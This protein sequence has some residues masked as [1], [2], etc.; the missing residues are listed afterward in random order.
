MEFKRL[1]LCTLQDSPNGFSYVQDKQNRCKLHCK[2]LSHFRHS[3]QITKLRSD[4][5]SKAILLFAKVNLELWGT[6]PTHTGNPYS[7]KSTAAEIQQE[8]HTFPSLQLSNSGEPTP[9][10][11]N[12]VA[13]CTLILHSLRF[14]DRTHWPTHVSRRWD[15]FLVEKRHGRLLCRHDWRPGA[16]PHG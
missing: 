13:P 3:G 4:R 14:L 15:V 6:Y 2:S 5:T 8:I 9:P 7:S 10:D 11:M 16:S 1:K 12:L